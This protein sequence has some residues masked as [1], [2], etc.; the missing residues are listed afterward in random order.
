MSARMALVLLAM[1]APGFPAGI[2][3]L[4]TDAGR[5]G[6]ASTLEIF[7]DPGGRLALEDIRALGPAAWA[8]APGGLNFGITRSTFWGRF[9]VVEA[10][11]DT[12]QWR[13]EVTFPTLDLVEVYQLTHGVRV[14]RAG[15]SLP[16]HARPIDH[17]N[18]QFDL[19]LPPGAAQTIYI[20]FRSAGAVTL[21]VQ[22]MTTDAIVRRDT[23]TL[24]ALGTFFGIVVAIFLYNLFLFISM[25]DTSYLWFV[26]SVMG[27]GSYAVTQAGLAYQLL[28]PGAPAWAHRAP[29][30]WLG[31]G[32][33]FSFQFARAFLL[34]PEHVPKGD[35]VLR[36][37]LVVTAVATALSMV[38]PTFTM[39][40]VLLGVC[41]VVLCVSG[42]V[43]AALS[44]WRGFRPALYYVIAWALPFALGTV[45][46]LLSFGLVPYK[47]WVVDGMQFGMAG[48]L[49]ILSLGLADR[50]RILRRDKEVAEIVS[51]T[52]GLT[53]VANRRRFDEYLDLEWRRCRRSVTPLSVVIVDVDDFK[54]FNDTYGHQKGDAALRAV[55]AALERCL[56]RPG[57]LVARYGGEEF[58]LIMPDTDSRGAA[59]VA[60]ATREAVAEL[61]IP[62]VA[63]SAA[64]TVTISLGCATLTPRDSDAIANV[65]A[66]ADRALYQAKD[67]GKN[68]VVAY[69]EAETRLIVGPGRAAGEESKA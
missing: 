57:D 24:L 12:R 39:G 58:A 16:F 2:V 21:P 19:D 67:L 3:E 5:V 52:D 8:T 62:H 68:Q 23:R 25:R 64:S 29:L 20:R 31:F 22:L 41:A 17:R 50:I 32:L 49:V 44:W 69:S 65:V 48:S 61:S 13:L 40:V 66:A 42:L 26:L 56:R 38:G 33:F 18:L 34:T 35:R 51:T 4:P 46:G 59:S 15:D 28:W 9:T 36:A 47:G 60:E 27:L 6:I 54:L 30:F 14:E 43:V 53:G 10:A 11:S 45:L 55:A 7:E 1:A 63:A 37:S